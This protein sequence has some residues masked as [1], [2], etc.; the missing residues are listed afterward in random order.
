MVFSGKDYLNPADKSRRVKLN[1]EVESIMKRLYTEEM[2]VGDEDMLEFYALFLC[3]RYYF[4]FRQF[5]PEKIAQKIRNR[6]EIYYPSRLHEESAINRL[7]KKIEKYKGDALIKT[8]FDFAIRIAQKAASRPGWSCIME[9]V[10][11]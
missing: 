5:T 3:K 4:E 11:L 8:D 7:Y 2:R 10:L 1:Y 9:E 6:S